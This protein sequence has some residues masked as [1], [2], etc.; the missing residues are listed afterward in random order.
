MNKA[1]IAII[2]IVLGHS[3]TCI[4][5]DEVL[6]RVNSGDRLSISVWR[7]EEL[8]G[9]VLV[10]PDGNCTFPL[11]GQF[12]ARG[13]T[14]LEIKEE[15][16]RRMARFVPDPVVTVSL[17]AI[18]GNII[19]VM[20][21]VRSPGQFV[22]NPSLDVMQALSVAGGTTPFA[23]LKSIRILRRTE[24]GQTALRFRYDEV[25]QGRNL[26]QN[27]LLRSGDLVVVP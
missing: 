3:A 27:I 17:A 10:A 2:W 23:D 14:L 19:Y 18:S 5:A 24:E 20:G 12:A 11:V 8:T 1:M 26:E 4:A 9:E 7:D 6:Y 13:R 15:L 21:H 25:I 16:S 22:M